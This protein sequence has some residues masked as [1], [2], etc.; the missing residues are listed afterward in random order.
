MKTRFPS[1]WIALV[2]LGA[3]IAQTNDL[4]SAEFYPITSI[5]SSTAA[6]DFFPVINLIQGPGVGYS[7]FEPHDAV[8]PAAD[9]LWV[10]NNPGGGA[11]YYESTGGV[12]PV[13]PS[14]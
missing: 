6:D 9:T 7:E 14:S 8:A 4:Q 2:A 1:S 3:V 12:A 11:D 5:T 10:T 13:L